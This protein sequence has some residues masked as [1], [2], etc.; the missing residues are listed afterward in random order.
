MESFVAFVSEHPRP[1]CLFF[2]ISSGAVERKGIALGD[3]AHPAHESRSLCCPSTTS[4]KI[5]AFPLAVLRTKSMSTRD[6]RAW[7][8]RT[9]YHGMFPSGIPSVGSRYRGV[10][11]VYCT[12]LYSIFHYLGYPA[13]AF[14]TL[15]A[16]RLGP[17]LGP[18]PL[19]DRHLPSLRPI[20]TRSISHSLTARQDSC[21]SQTLVSRRSFIR[22]LPG[23]RQ[24]RRYLTVHSPQPPSSATCFSNIRS[25]RCASLLGSASRLCNTSL[26]RPGL[27][28]SARPV[29]WCRQAALCNFPAVK[30][31]VR[32]YAVESSQIQWCN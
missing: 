6:S 9:V 28:A 16:A 31:R 15:H 11:C 7:A 30:P 29:V 26:R 21:E 17:P 19:V 25:M 4:H 13:R 20:P 27:V 14:S 1:F 8:T 10:G 22:H 18:F 32:L 2:P 12:A 5:L 24:S 23:N 3:A